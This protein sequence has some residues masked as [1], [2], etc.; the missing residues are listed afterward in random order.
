MHELCRVEVSPDLIS[1]VTN[2]VLEEVRAWQNRLLDAVCPVVF[3]DAL[4]VRIRDE[5][6]VR[7]R[8]AC[9]ALGITCQGEKEV[10]GLWIGLKTRGVGDIPI[11]VVDGFP[12]RN[13][14]GVPT[15]R[16]PDLHRASDPQL[17]GFRLLEGPQGGHARSEGRLPG[18]DDRG[19]SSQAGCVRSCL[20]V[21]LSGDRAGLAA[22]LAACGADVR[23]LAGDPKADSCDECP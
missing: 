15:D 16:G 9:L 19:G 20:G 18:R 3:F 13:R 21:A 23:F 22:R 5:G 4:R 17:A 14:D 12:R 7:D 6:L 2:A 10:L 1:R 8:A 11:A